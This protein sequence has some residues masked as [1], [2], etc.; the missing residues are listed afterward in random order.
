[1]R[2][3]IDGISWNRKC[4]SPSLKWGASKLTSL[5]G[6]GLEAFKGP[7]P[8]ELL[9]QVKDEFANGFGRQALRRD[10]SGPISPSFCYI[11]VDGV[12]QPT[13][14]CSPIAF[15]PIGQFDVGLTR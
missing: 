6:L 1:M 7:K 3:F 11:L 2:G 13:V 9:N 8:I 4:R 5:V 10:L 15:M 14:C 12:H